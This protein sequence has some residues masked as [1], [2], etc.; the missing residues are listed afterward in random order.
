MLKKTV[1]VMSLLTF[2]L[3]CLKFSSFDVRASSDH[4]VRNLDSGL[5]YL[6]IQEAI[7]APET[8]VGHTIFVD[9]GTYYESVVVNKS[10]SL[11]GA[12]KYTTIIDGNRSA[13]GLGIFSDEVA[14][15][16]LTVVHSYAG[17]DDVGGSLFVGVG[18]LATVG[19][20]QI[21]DIIICNNDAMGIHLVPGIHDINI[22]RVT[23]I[24]NST[25]LGPH[26]G[27][28]LNEAWKVNIRNSAV[29]C[30]SDSGIVIH[31]GGNH[32]IIGNNITNNGFGIWLLAGSLN[33]TI[34]GN[35][36]MNN[37]EGIRSGNSSNLL[38]RG[39]I[40]MSNNV[41]VHCVNNSM[42]ELH[43]N[44]ISGNYDFNV[45]NDDSLLAVNAT[46][47]YWGDGPDLEKIFGNVL[48]DPWLT[49]SIFYSEI[50]NP[51]SRATVSSTVKISTEG[52]TRSGFEKVEFYI[53]NK[54]ESV[55]YDAP[56]EWNWNTTQYTQ[57]EHEITAKAYDLLGLKIST[58]IT[59]FVD[60]TP[61]TVSIETPTPQNIYSGTIDVDVN[62]TDNKE[63]SN[64]HV[65]VDD[66]EW[67]V[68]TKDPIE[69]LWKYDLNTT[70]LS[71]GQHTIT[72]LALDKAGNPAINS[73]TLLTDNNPPT[74]AIRTPQSGMTVGITLIVDVEASDVSG[75]SRLEFY[76][77]DVLA[78][79]VTST[80]YQWSWDTTKYPNGEY[81]IIVKAYDML[82]IVQTREATVTVKNVESTWWQTHFW[83]IIQALV[84][85]GGLM[86]GVA[87]Y[88]TQKKKR[89]KK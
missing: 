77:Q 74:L 2:S 84:A 27:L 68:M 70:I 32:S 46:H 71:D 73:T 75:I 59:V 56:Y 51:L 14:V 64:V 21:S 47:N 63:L 28:L 33:N 8:S 54:L 49:E 57:T 16:N 26:C 42:T 82:G 72:V 65:R 80:P 39:N 44:D 53:D 81:R 41:G 58:S 29:V 25:Q 22:T 23:I 83:T 4:P 20:V 6:S 1:V 69:L 79:T 13:I 24:N 9:P 45:K 31:N 66:T 89:R 67:L 15:S 36:I 62:A 17:P 40:I 38:V 48:Y 52:W 61:P 43:W 55:D 19:N 88:L 3:L 35:M 87:T 37:G 5:S 18:E 12:D 60:N 10:V 85:T 30:S 86:L 7:N 11:V 34:L 76:L 50:T 78:H